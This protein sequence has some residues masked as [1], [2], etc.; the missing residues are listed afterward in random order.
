[1]ES[2]TDQEKTSLQKIKQQTKNY[3][4]MI[5]ITILSLILTTLPPIRQTIIMKLG[6]IVTPIL[7]LI[8]AY[9]ALL[10][11]FARCPRCNKYFYGGTLDRTFHQFRWVKSYGRTECFYCHLKDELDIQATDLTSGSVKKNEVKLEGK[12]ILYLIGLGMG[13]PLTFYGTK[14]IIEKKITLPNEFGWD[15]FTGL[16]AFLISGF[17]L[18]I[19]TTFLFGVIW[20]LILD[21]K[22]KS[23]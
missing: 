4:R 10:V 23:K 8:F 6:L 21:I 16:P 3:R 5:I 2:I 17:L 14:G 9:Y 22:K 12:L 11:M 19:G 1:M 15:E 18:A 20:Q 13:I 7:V